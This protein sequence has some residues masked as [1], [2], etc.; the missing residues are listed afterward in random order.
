MGR[1]KKG[2][3][4]P[5]V[6]SNVKY[7]TQLDTYSSASGLLEQINNFLVEH[8]LVDAEIEIRTIPDYYDTVYTELWITYWGPKQEK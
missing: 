3:I 8:N 5:P 6:A 7:E 4:K 1:K 2:A